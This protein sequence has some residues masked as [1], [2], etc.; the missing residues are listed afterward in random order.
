MYP[1]SVFLKSCLTD[2]KSA[3]MRSVIGSALS[4]SRTSSESL[5][6]PSSWLFMSSASFAH[7]FLMES[8][9]IITFR[10]RLFF[11][12]GNFSLRLFIF[13]T[14]LSALSRMIVG[15]FPDMSL[16]RMPGLS[17]LPVSLFFTPNIS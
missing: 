4:R 1:G 16:P 12:G 6:G 7:S 17:T 2:V 14:M 9:A 8:N 11:N 13:E 5:N 15:G 3:T 10:G